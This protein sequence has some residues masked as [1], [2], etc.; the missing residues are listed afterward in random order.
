MLSDNDYFCVIAF[1]LTAA[2]VLK[3]TRMNDA[4]KI[5]AEQMIKKLYAE[6]GTNIWSALALGNKI[7]NMK[8]FANSNV[9]TALLTFNNSFDT[10]DQ[11]PFNIIEMY[12]QLVRPETL[13]VFGFGY[14]IMKNNNELLTQLA[15]IG[16]GNFD[17]I[18][19]ITKV[20]TVFINWILTMFDTASLKQKLTITYDDNSVMSLQTRLIQYGHSQEFVS[21]SS[22]KPVSI[23]LDSGPSVASIEV[24]VL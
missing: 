21:Y 14:N 18:P 12:A 23:V 17:F 22:A 16:R 13:Y 7:S 10:Y 15:T 5:I 3:P 4:G 2:V 1:N 20:E 8:E 19:D 9:V 11:T 24:D 6:G